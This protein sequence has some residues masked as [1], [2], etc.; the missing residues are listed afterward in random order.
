MAR[1]SHPEIRAKCQDAL[2]FLC[3]T[4]T[5]EDEDLDWRSP[6]VRSLKH[7]CPFKPLA[8]AVRPWLP[9]SR[10]VAVTSLCSGP[11]V[12]TPSKPLGASYLQGRRLAGAA[13][14]HS[15]AL[16]GSKGRISFLRGV[17]SLD[18]SVRLRRISPADQAD[19]ARRFAAV[20]P[21]VGYTCSHKPS[22]LDETRGAVSREESI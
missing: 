8:G 10:R 12:S 19:A 5:C 17:R 7:K 11:N 22:A 21:L 3:R 6:L 16:K 9:R 15:E 20:Q 2:E 18:V 4:A 14:F 1:V 13:E